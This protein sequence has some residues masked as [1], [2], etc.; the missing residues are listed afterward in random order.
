[1]ELTSVLRGESFR[2]FATIVAPGAIGLAPWAAFLYSWNGSGR[3]FWDSHPIATGV[4][5][6]IASVAAGLV[7]ENI[8]A[9]VEESID[10]RLT[11]KDKEHERTWRRYLLLTFDKEPIG[12]RYL[13]TIL[14]RLKFELGALGSLFVAL[15]G[16][17]VF[18]RYQG[19][20]SVSLGGTVAIGAV[21]LYWFYREALE[22][23]EVLARLRQDLVTE[24]GRRP[25]G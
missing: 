10:R 22:S 9:R 12:Q 1:M 21:L 5:L 25:T 7:F 13:R 23:A 8:G 18:L 17:F 15:P 2:P 14:F 24:F 3:L 19:A 20:S 6:F 16:W 4:V 11:K